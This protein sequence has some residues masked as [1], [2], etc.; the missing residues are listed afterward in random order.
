MQPTG[1]EPLEKKMPKNTF[2]ATFANGEKVT[3]KTNASSPFTTP[4]GLEFVHR[5]V[6]L[7]PTKI[8]NGERVR[9]IQG[10]N[11]DGSWT[12]SRNAKVLSTFKSEDKS[13]VDFTVR[14]RTFLT[15]LQDGFFAV[16]IR[17]NIEHT[18]VGNLLIVDG[19]FI[20]QAGGNAGKTFKTKNAAIRWLVARE[21][22]G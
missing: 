3:R 11:H 13:I 2:T 22:E 15:K 10:Q 9:F 17:G 7:P 12:V 1:Y 6:L 19:Q 21:L 20:A 16:K 8:E 4:N 18:F 5:V 14:A